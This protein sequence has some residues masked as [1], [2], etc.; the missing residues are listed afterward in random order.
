MKFTTIAMV[1]AAASQVTALGGVPESGARRSHAELY[2]RDFGMGARNVKRQ[3]AA[4]A[5]HRE[6]IP[7]GRKGK[8]A[9]R[10]EEQMTEYTTVFVTVT[11]K[12]DGTTVTASPASVAAEATPSAVA[13]EVVEDDEE[14]VEEVVETTVTE[15][16]TKLATV[17]ST[18]EST[19]DAP[20]ATSTSIIAP[21]ETPEATTTTTEEPVEEETAAPEK[22]KQT[23][24]TVTMTECEDVCTTPTA[25]PAPVETPKAPVVTPAPVE[26]PVP[27][28][29]ESETPEAETPAAPTPAPEAPVET[30]EE[31][32]PPVLESPPFPVYNGT[33]N[34]TAPL[35]GTF[36]GNATLPGNCTL[37]LP[38][39]GT[40]T[41]PIFANPAPSVIH[42]TFTV[43]PVAP[44]SVVDE[45]QVLA[46]HPQVEKAVASPVQEAPNVNMTI[47]E[48]E[49]FDGAAGAVGMSW[50]VAA[51][52]GVVGVMAWL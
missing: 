5:Y 17:T 33:F 48:G 47:E 3:Q 28:P 27:A 19:A 46:A 16:T 22:P 23:W 26:T 6:Y 7:E 11:M 13:D 30:P 49:I 10:E 43:I 31:T 34:C 45:P 2:R 35:N 41:T 8:V 32:L 37:P 15:S 21:I 42:S 40:I 4:Q 18:G 1:A 52:A 14:A 29:A 38:A 44:T 36:A 20:A 39:N 25:T 51:L 24:T 50:S 12:K 9:K